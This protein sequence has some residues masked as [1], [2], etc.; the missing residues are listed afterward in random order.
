MFPRFIVFTL[1]SGLIVALPTTTTTTAT[2]PT[3]TTTPVEDIFILNGTSE[4]L[5]SIKGL[6]DI[7]NDKWQKETQA[8]EF[9]K[10]DG[11]TCV[12]V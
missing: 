4:K 10:L 11:K 1:A 5:E 7:P 2:T 8:E 6:N 9:H 12:S 3:I